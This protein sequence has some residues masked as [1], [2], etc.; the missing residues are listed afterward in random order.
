M[1]PNS[2]VFA[3][4]S[5]LFATLGFAASA[6][7][8]TSPA[9][10]AAGS[11]VQAYHL[12]WDYSY[13]QDID[14]DSGF[15]T[16]THRGNCSGSTELPMTASG[17]GA[18]IYEGGGKSSGA[19]YYRQTFHTDNGEVWE[20]SD[21]LGDNVDS[22]HKA[23]LVV[24]DDG[25]YH[26]APPVPL[27]QGTY[28]NI[29]GQ[30]MAATRTPE[31]PV[32]VS[33]KV[34]QGPVITF[35][36]TIEKEMLPG[37]MLRIRLA[38]T[39]SPVGPPPKLLLKQTLKTFVPEV[40]GTVAAQVIQVGRRGSP[41][42]IRFILAEVTREPGLCLNGPETG[43]LADL[44]FTVAGNLG[45]FHG[46]VPK[47]DSG[48]SIQT[49]QPRL[50]ATCQI[51]VRDY[52][53]WGKLSAEAFYD[54]AWHPIPVQK[55]RQPFTTVPLD[56]KLNKIA[57]AW[58]KKN[59]L[60]NAAGEGDLDKTPSGD[61]R[62]LGDGYTNYEEY[63]GLFTKQTHVRLNPNRKELA[64]EN[65]MGSQGDGGLALFE[66]AS[67]FALIRLASGELPEDRVVNKHTS[68]LFHKGDQHGLRMVSAAIG[69]G[70]LGEALP[71]SLLNKRPGQCTLVRIDPAAVQ[72]TTPPSGYAAE[73]A[74]TI[75]HE[76]AHGI[77]VD[78]H[79]NPVLATPIRYIT[80][81]DTNYRIFA[82]DGSEIK[83]RPYEIKGALGGPHNDASGDTSCVMCYTS[84]YQWCVVPPTGP[85]FALYGAK[86]PITGTRFCRNARGTGMN[87]NGKYFDSAARGNCLGQ[88]RV[89]DY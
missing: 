23:L 58:E 12:T 34:P 7:S 89:K 73:L 87:A 10:A 37:R 45:V 74:S 56:L 41:V 84:V 77:G 30:T 55:S 62:T 16:F 61:G 38:I 72:A 69:G 44:D 21:C 59:K 18:F 46:A 83:T 5:A 75:A 8:H 82:S 48:W 35:D 22:L 76:L 4:L 88:M 31:V 50:N 52:G 79:G 51:G 40:G 81:R 57:D 25:T 17:N 43:T 64:V 85:N 3:L 20:E 68:G 15:V 14:D 33:E 11:T 78:H 54:G 24:R 6:A 29:A 2:R 47:G 36:G 63:R 60:K 26:F 32:I 65:K 86:P 42:P 1:K 70:V 13:S 49:R 39:L 67:G 28:R 9:P 19:A 71:L 53:A 66:G 80:D 27:F